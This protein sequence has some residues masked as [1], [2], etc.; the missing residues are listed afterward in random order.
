M[1]RT[2][3]RLE[4]DCDK[5]NP[6]EY[7]EIPSILRRVARMIQDGGLSIHDDSKVL[8]TDSVDDEVGKAEFVDVH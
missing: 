4:I 2:V 3:F 8:L 5:L 7:E 1:T 6:R